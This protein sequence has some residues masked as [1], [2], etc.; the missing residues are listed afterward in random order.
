MASGE[1][2]WLADGYDTLAHAAAID[3][4]ATLLCVLLAQPD[5]DTAIDQMHRVAHLT[6]G[7]ARAITLRGSE[8]KAMRLIRLLFAL[9]RLRFTRWWWQ[10]KRF[11]TSRG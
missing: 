5:A 3:D 10:A 1:I 9:Y 2:V 8:G 7:H 11:L 4:Y 6:V